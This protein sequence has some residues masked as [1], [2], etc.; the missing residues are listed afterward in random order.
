MNTCG[1]CAKWLRSPFGMSGTCT[2]CGKPI[3][4]KH[5]ACAEYTESTV[6]LPIPKHEISVVQKTFAPSKNGTYR[7][8]HKI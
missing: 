4:I 7:L 1:K 5:K 8:I 2:L 6:S 3:G